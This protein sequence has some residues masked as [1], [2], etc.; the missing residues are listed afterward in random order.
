MVAWAVAMLKRD[1]FQF[2]TAHFARRP[3]STVVC[4][5]FGLCNISPNAVRIS[6]PTDAIVGQFA[7]HVV[8][9]FSDTS[10]D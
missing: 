6:G 8:C 3:G 2:S 10:L 1:L 9:F 7:Q 5:N 4:I